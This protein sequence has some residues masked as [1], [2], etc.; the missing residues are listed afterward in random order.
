MGAGQLALERFSFGFLF[1]LEG[2]IAIRVRV[3]E[4]ASLVKFPALRLFA[5]EFIE[6]SIRLR[7]DPAIKLSLRDLE[8]SPLLLLLA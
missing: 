4:S 8:G 5:L 3:P 1:L 7:L 2:R 6:P